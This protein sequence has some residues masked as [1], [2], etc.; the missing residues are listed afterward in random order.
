MNR[1]EIPKIIN[2]SRFYRA[3]NKEFSPERCI[4][5]T[6]RRA[7]VVMRKLC[8]HFKVES[9]PIK[10]HGQRKGGLALHKEREIRLPHNPSCLMLCHEI[11]HILSGDGHSKKCLRQLEQIIVYVRKRKYWFD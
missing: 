6:D 7:K 8:K 11:A 2:K 9:I 1:M 3:E 10:F 4:H 5:Y